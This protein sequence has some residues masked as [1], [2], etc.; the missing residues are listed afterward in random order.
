MRHVCFAP[1][2]KLMETRDEPRHLSSGEPDNDLDSMR[3]KVKLLERQL[4]A[5]KEIKQ[6]QEEQVRKVAPL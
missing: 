2:Q 5:E 6:R 4:R 3:D 1:A